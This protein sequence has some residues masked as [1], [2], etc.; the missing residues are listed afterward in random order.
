VVAVVAALVAVAW[1]AQSLDGQGCD[2]DASVV[3]DVHSAVRGEGSGRGVV[4]LDSVAEVEEGCGG[5]DVEGRWPPGTL[6]GRL[7]PWPE[8]TALPLR[9]ETRLVGVARSSGPEEVDW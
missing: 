8:E 4:L 9:V 6:Y 2:D 3:S 7:W 5:V 1:D